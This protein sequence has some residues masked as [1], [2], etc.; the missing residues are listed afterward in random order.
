MV[1]GV[2]EP[3]V[4]LRS[5]PGAALPRLHPRTHDFH[6]TR[7]PPRGCACSLAL[8]LV[9]S[10]RLWRRLS[11]LARTAF[12]VPAP[13]RAWLTEGVPLLASRLVFLSWGLFT[14]NVC[15]L[16]PLFPSQTVGE[17]CLVCVSSPTKRPA[18][19]PGFFTVFSGSW[20]GV[21]LTKRSSVSFVPLRHHFSLGETQKA[22]VL[23][24]DFF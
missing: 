15:F 12:Q 22:G 10:D 4:S 9:R 1:Q 7:P 8:S 3:S 20:A 23:A 21:P 18:G 14:R 24:L 17:R 16:E 2:E 6:V 13:W 5:E 11:G 19:G